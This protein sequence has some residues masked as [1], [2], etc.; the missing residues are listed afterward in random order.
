M[1]IP[2]RFVRY[3]AFLRTAPGKLAAIA[4]ATIAL[5]SLVIGYLDTGIS[6]VKWA[7]WAWERLDTPWLGLFAL[8]TIA[9][10]LWLAER[11]LAK[12]ERSQTLAR[13]QIMAV[14]R[15]MAT[16]TV[17]LSVVADLQ[18]RVTK[19]T[20][21]LEVVKNQAGQWL[22]ETD[23]TWSRPQWEDFER[24]IRRLWSPLTFEPS[25]MTPVAIESVQQPAL[26][27]PSGLPVEDEY[28]GPAAWQNFQALAESNTSFRTSLRHN[29]QEAERRIEQ[30]RNYLMEGERQLRRNLEDIQKE[31]DL[32]RHQSNH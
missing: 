23:Y 16:R 4:F 17:L 3:K 20:A 2:S 24:A 6:A 18:Q 10:C 28:D 26:S 13:E 32:D 5:V 21:E 25:Q 8:V 31:I 7:S 14:P 9:L 11:Q 19:A 29:L 30:L 15:L 27:S 22:R 1:G 12:E